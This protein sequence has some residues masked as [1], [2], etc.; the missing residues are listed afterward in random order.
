MALGCTASTSPAPGT[1]AVTICI[2][3]PP[4]RPYTS[5]A[6]TA[7]A[8]LVGRK[9]SVITSKLILTFTTTKTEKH[10]RPKNK[11]TQQTTT[12]QRATPL[13]C[14]RCGPMHNPSS[15]APSSTA[16]Q[17]RV[18]SREENAPRLVSTPPAFLH[19]PTALLGHPSA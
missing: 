10:E 18:V 15:N 9:S 7:V 11:G 6:H 19:S 1:S 5:A 12:Q 4:R 13:P 3:F 2:S 14:G 16:L 8:P 17:H